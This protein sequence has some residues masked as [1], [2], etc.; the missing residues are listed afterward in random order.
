MTVTSLFFITFEVFHIT[1]I[2]SEYIIDLLVSKILTRNKNLTSSNKENLLPYIFPMAVLSHSTQS[3][4]SMRK[5]ERKWPRRVRHKINISPMIMCTT[6]L[7]YFSTQIILQIPLSQRFHLPEGM[8]RM[9]MCLCHGH[10]FPGVKL[11]DSDHTEGASLS[12]C[13]ESPSTI[14]TNAGHLPM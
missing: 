6:R 10:T 7:F 12:R 4:S 2:Y 11:P 9:S 1:T 3:T 5:T 14:Q 8:Q 13:K